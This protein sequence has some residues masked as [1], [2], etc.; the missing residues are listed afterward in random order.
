MSQTAY[1]YRVETRGPE[2]VGKVELEASLELNRPNW[3]FHQR[4]RH[5]IQVDR[6]EPAEWAHGIE[7]I[8]TVYG[9]T[10]VLP[11]PV[12]PFRRGVRAKT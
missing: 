9:S 10:P 3:Y 8:P 6:I 12:P 7:T 1:L 5:V 4:Q 11:K 2:Y